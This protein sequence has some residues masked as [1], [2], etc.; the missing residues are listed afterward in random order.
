MG[1]SEWFGKLGS[2]N[3]IVERNG[4]ALDDIGTLVEEGNLNS[5]WHIIQV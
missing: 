3:V 5:V 2:R 1:E 4:V